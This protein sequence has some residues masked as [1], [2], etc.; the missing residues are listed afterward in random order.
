MFDY[1]LRPPQQVYSQLLSQMESL[2]TV[3]S[4]NEVTE[5]STTPA[6][7]NHSDY[8]P[9]FPRSPAQAIRLTTMGLLSLSVFI[10]II[11]V[12]C[13]IATVFTQNSVHFFGTSRKI[14]RKKRRKDRPEPL[15]LSVDLEAQDRPRHYLVLPRP[16]SARLSSTVS[17]GSAMRRT[18]TSTVEMDDLASIMLR[19]GVSWSGDVQGGEEE[20]PL[21]LSRYFFDDG[22]GIKRYESWTAERLRKE[23]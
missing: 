17:P 15:D 19:R 8:R 21:G 22:I 23:E 2:N 9:P 14:G 16:C 6:L 5:Q 20:S 13:V 4:T 12:M 1:F 3:E 10:L 11:L 7:T 18:G